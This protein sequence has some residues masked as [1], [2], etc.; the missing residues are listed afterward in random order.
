MVDKKDEA[1]LT[2]VEEELF[3]WHEMRFRRIG[4]S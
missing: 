4:V 1:Q 3:A 2:P